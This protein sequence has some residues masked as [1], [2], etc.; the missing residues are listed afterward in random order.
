MSWFPERPSVRQAIRRAD[1]RFYIYRRHL[2]CPGLHHRVL[3]CDAHGVRVRIDLTT[4]VDAGLE[5]ETVEGE[6]V[7]VKKDV[8]T[9]EVAVTGLDMEE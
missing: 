8:A 3:E 4:A 5:M 6:V 1:K 2:R 7:T 9:S